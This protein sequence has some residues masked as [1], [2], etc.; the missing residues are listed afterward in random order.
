MIEIALSILKNIQIRNN[1]IRMIEGSAKLGFCII[2]NRLI[3]SGLRKINGVAPHTETEY[4]WNQE[5]RTLTNKATTLKSKA[6]RI[7]QKKNNPVNA[8]IPATG[9]QAT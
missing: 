5:T 8:A 2:L 6:R 9:F 3:A 1:K 4:T 7:P